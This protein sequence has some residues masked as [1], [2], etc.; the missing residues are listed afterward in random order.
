MLNITV[1][2]E[3]RGGYSSH[4]LYQDLDKVELGR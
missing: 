3:N 2:K 1:T 4:K